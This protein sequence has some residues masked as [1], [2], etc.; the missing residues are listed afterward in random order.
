MRTHVEFRNAK[1]APCPGEANEVTPHRCGRRLID[2][3]ARVEQ[4]A[5]AIDRALASD[6]DV[7]DV[8]RWASAEVAA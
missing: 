1:C 6:R 8:R 3:T 4:L 7:A 5:D 2:T